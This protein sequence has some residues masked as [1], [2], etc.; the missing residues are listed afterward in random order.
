[1]RSDDEKRILG[2]WPKYEDGGYVMP[3]DVAVANNGA[4]KGRA[5]TVLS[6]RVNTVGVCLTDCDGSYWNYKAGDRRVKRPE[7]KVLDADGV[8]IKVGDTVYDTELANGDKFTVENIDKNGDVSARGNKYILTQSPVAFTHRAPVLTADGR[9]LR[10]GETVW[11]GK[12]NGPYT[13]KKIEDDGII[14]IDLNDLDY[15]ASE[16]FSERPDSWERLERD[17]E[18]SI[19]DYFGSSSSPDS[20]CKDGCPGLN[21]PVNCG[22]LMKLDLIRRAKALAEKEAAR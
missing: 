20:L 16:F 13:I 11:D 9:P 14:R 3:G 17:A 15:F 12:G 19:C 18:K 5:F 1:M 6:V 2:L 7:P 8:E 10:E 4:K 21:S 22:V